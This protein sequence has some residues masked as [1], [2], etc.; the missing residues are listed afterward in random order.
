MYARDSLIHKGGG[1]DH[2]VK[3]S[4]NGT[5]FHSFLYP[6]SHAHTPPYIHL[7]SHLSMH[8]P[9]IHLCMS[10]SSIYSLTYPSIQTISSIFF[11]LT[12]INL[13]FSHITI[14]AARTVWTLGERYLGHNHRMLELSL[15]FKE[16]CAI[17]QEHLSLKGLQVS[18]H[19]SMELIIFWDIQLQVSNF[20]PPKISRGKYTIDSSV[21]RKLRGSGSQSKPQKLWSFL[22]LT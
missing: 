6:P 20:F 15:F 13:L 4:F 9:I 14:P 3:S 2:F 21:S 5:G 1:K 12:Y 18:Q 10:H 11:L 19:R 22:V 16:T 8:P 17:S 7:S